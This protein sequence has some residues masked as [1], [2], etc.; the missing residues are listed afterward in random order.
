MNLHLFCVPGTGDIRSILDAARP[1]LAAQPE[2]VVAYLPSAASGYNWLDYTEKA[3][4]GLGQVAYV[5]PETMP[6]AD[7]EAILARAGLIYISGGNTFLLNHRLHQSGLYPRL[8]ARIH[9]GLPVVGFSAGATICGPNI[10]T[11][12][13]MNMCAT[14]HFTGLD[15]TPY[16]FSVHYPSDDQSRAEWDEWL[17]QYHVTF[18]NPILALEDDAYL[19]IDDERTVLVRGTGWILAKGHP[20]Q[21]V[22]V[23]IP[24]DAV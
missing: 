19:Q 16:N 18:D 9:A 20:R 8:R 10:R 2:P 1:Y 17:N 11:S 3:F 12:K 13:D 15:L 21:R 7:I 23:G 6:L 14:T 5:D 4:A 22:A 24:V